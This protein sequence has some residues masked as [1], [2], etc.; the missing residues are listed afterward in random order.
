MLILFGLILN[1]IYIC[2]VIIY[3]SEFILKMVVKEQRSFLLEEV[4]RTERGCVYQ[5]DAENCLYVD[6]GGRAI[7]YRIACFFRLKALVDKINLTAM[8]ANPDRSSDVEIISLCACEHCYVLTL[9]EIVA[10]KELLAGAR[11][12]IELNSILK[13]RLHR[14]VK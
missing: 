11:V 7:K 9:S 3:P 1:S 2:I 6:F 12:M 8:A 4:F 14:L 10:L 5:S 13:E